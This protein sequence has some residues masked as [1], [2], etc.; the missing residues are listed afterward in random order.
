MLSKFAI[1]K[2]P[3]FKTDQAILKVCAQTNKEPNNSNQKLIRRFTHNSKWFDKT[4][5]S[6]TYITI[7]INKL[8]RSS[9]HDI[10]LYRWEPKQITKKRITKSRKYGTKKR[11]SQ[12]VVVFLVLHRA[13]HWPLILKNINECFL[14][15]ST[16]LSLL[17]SHGSIIQR[18]KQLVL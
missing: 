14:S 11:C 1:T 6:K 16:T 4:I 12:G 15:W 5:I 7:G 2:L 18:L 8:Y 9:N 13:P 3:K 10:W 17:T